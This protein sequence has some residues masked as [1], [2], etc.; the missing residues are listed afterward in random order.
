M[1]DK[2]IILR[3]DLTLRKLATLEKLRIDT[4]PGKKLTGQD[5]VDLILYGKQ[6]RIFKELRYVSK[7][8]E[9]AKL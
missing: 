1:H 5:V 7:A 3:S 8:V 9:C 2:T 6:S 4:E